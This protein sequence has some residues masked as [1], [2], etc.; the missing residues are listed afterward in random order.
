[1]EQFLT[2]VFIALMVGGLFV[3]ALSLTALLLHAFDFNPPEW[4]TN[5]GVLGVPTRIVAA[6][7]ILVFSYLVAP[8]LSGLPFI[9]PFHEPNEMTP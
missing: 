1:M 9:D 8:L 6:L 7:A 5:P 3:A 2:V 4:M